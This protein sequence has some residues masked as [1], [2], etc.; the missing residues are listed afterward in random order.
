M[1]KPLSDENLF[2]K[3]CGVNVNKSSEFGSELVQKSAT[4]VNASGFLNLL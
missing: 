4:V 1:I 3:R 2:G